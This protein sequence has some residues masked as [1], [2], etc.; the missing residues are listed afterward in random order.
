MT[1]KTTIEAEELKD[2]LTWVSRA[3][4]KTPSI[5]ALTGI[6]I[7]AGEGTAT[8][9]AYDFA[10]SARIQVQADTESQGKLLIHGG[11]LGSV[12]KALSDKPVT[13]E[14][15][16]SLAHICSGRSQHTLHAMR[17]QGHPGL[18]P[19][20][21]TIGQVSGIRFADA[22]TRVGSFAETAH[23]K[24]LPILRGIHLRADH[25]GLT[26]MATNRIRAGIEQV[27]W[28]S[29]FE[30]QGFAVTVPAGRLITTAKALKSTGGV[31][32]G[33]D[34]EAEIF[35]LTSGN[36]RATLPLMGDDFPV[37]MERLFPA[38]FPISLHAETAALLGALRRTSALASQS[39]GVTIQ[40]QGQELHIE[41]A[42]EREQEASEVI[43][44]SSDSTE[45]FLMPFA[46][47]NL[48]AALS[49]VPREQTI[50]GI[51]GSRN[52]AHI[53]SSDVGATEQRD[54]RALIM[55]RGL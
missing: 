23:D 10:A 43:D 9:G 34:A 25:A 16:G 14:S 19:M 12:V 50:I 48:T 7:S 1:F 2:A 54:F 41:S 33:F 46:V 51:T 24:G 36:R 28:Q 38:E 45:D 42:D 52:P 13:I 26:M 5:P 30:E 49:A 21:P 53:T 11:H 20:P 37:N 3:W 47:S 15:S 18:P 27:P 40:K 22:V 44:I 55:P 35:G 6:L 29:T 4:E 32:L 17:H 31:D 8:L 39:S